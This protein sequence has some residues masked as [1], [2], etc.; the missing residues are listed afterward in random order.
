MLAEGFPQPD[1][2]FCIIAGKMEPGWES[3]K[4]MDLGETNTNEMEES[5]RGSLAI[6]A[7]MQSR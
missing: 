5:A 6:I 3:V 2:R 1:Q 4:K 7:P